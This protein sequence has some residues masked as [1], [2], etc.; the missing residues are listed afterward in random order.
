MGFSKKILNL[1][2]PKERY[3][4]ILLLILILFMAILE[5][6]GVASILPFVT[7]LT[8]PGIIETNLVLN[9]IFK[10]SIIFGIEN[11]QD[12]L[13]ALGILV[14]VL[15][16]TSLIFKALTAYVQIRFVQILQYNLSKRLLERYLSQ[17][18]S[19]FLTRNSADFSKTILA[20]T[21]IVIGN[22][23]STL[24]EL[25][26]KSAV[27]FALLVL[28]IL[29]SPKIALIVGF[30]LGMSYLLIYKLTSTY[31]SRLGE[32]RFKKQEFLF[33]SISEAFGAVKEIKMAG[34]EKIYVKLFSDPARTIAKT[35]ASS[36]V[37]QQLPRFALEIVAFGGIMLLILYQMK[38]TGSLNSALPVISL[39]AFAGYRLMPA[40]QQIYGS[41]SKF[42]FII[43]SVNKIHD[44][45]INLKILDSNNDQGVVPLKNKII[46]ENI[47]YSYPKASRKALKNINLSIPVNSTIGLVG[48][49]GSGKTT[50]VDI[51]LGLLEPQ[52]GNLKVD[53]KTITKQNSRVWQKSIGYVPQY[54]YLSDNSVAANIAFGIDPKEINHEAV[55]K[56]SKIANL[57]NFILDEL[58]KQYQTTIGER[59]VRLSG[60]QRQRIGIARALYHNPK[61]LILDEATNALDNLTEQAVMEAV[62]NL[63]KNIT[64]ILIAHRLNT[65]RKCDKIYLFDKG[66]I[67]NEG[68]FEELMKVNE[69]FRINAK[70]NN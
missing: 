12:F 14:F 36:S 50:T 60:G 44:D 41:L 39:Y 10:A 33:K 52:K 43:P 68:T 54:I 37:I 56:A 19:W 1:L 55:E 65:V 57:H 69:N 3:Q 22:G 13:F 2:V 35:T 18:Y 30:S 4:A 42:N 38:Q 58:P 59:G 70:I 51:I 63:S 24:L 47:H 34:L 15:L 23:V 64:I 49:T 26:A 31:V 67:K 20:E 25:I 45:F 11:N 5:M 27:A 53:E 8:N 40:L 32:E 61:V 29:A 9:K 48:A 46:L 62:N 17:S 28:L 66:E 16:V 7:V 6:I 21:G